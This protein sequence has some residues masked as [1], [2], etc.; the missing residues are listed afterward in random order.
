MYILCWENHIIKYACDQ[1]GAETIEII[2]G[3][4]AIQC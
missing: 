3:V 4:G 1:M 2:D